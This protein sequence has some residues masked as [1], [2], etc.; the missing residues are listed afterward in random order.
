MK[1]TKGVLQ[2]EQFDADGNSLSNSTAPGLSEFG[3]VQVD[4]EVVIGELN[5]FENV[6]GTAFN[7]TI[8]GNVQNN[9]LIGGAGDDALHPFGGDDFVDG[10]AGTDV[11]L[12]NGFAS[13]QLADI[14]EGTAQNLDGSG[15]L[16][17]FVNIE[18]VNGSSVAGDVILGSAG[19][20][21]LNGLGG[22]DR[23]N[24]RAGDDTLNGGAGTD[25]LDG[26]IGNDTFVFDGD[27]LNQDVED[28]IE[29]F[30][31]DDDRFGLSAS[32]FD[33]TG[34][35]SFVN[36]LAEDLPDG[37]V[38]AIVLQ[39]SDNDN[40][41]TTV[42][43]AR[44]AATLIAEQ[45]QEETAGFFVYFNS[46]LE[47]NRLVYSS[48]LG[49]ADADLSILARLDNAVGQEA[50]AALEDFSAENFALLA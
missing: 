22:D 49:D 36:A 50:I 13:G 9:V 37:G 11:L 42:F 18:N 20:N 3:N 7:D 43:N 45:I 23:L 27:T 2:P 44:L 30:T 32:D 39:N 5:D 48:N 31:F 28:T 34:E 10:G 41:P 40:D 15:T 25:T 14:A 6:I 16:N 1:T 4:G 26:G 21:V 29:D 12:L 47:V 24:G 46:G 35:L 17:I 8:F 33:I 38:N 19:A